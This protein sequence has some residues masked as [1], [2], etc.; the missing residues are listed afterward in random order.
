MW[1]LIEDFFDQNIVMKGMIGLGWLAV[2]CVA[3]VAMWFVL[4]PMLMDAGLNNFTLG[5]MMLG[6]L[7]VVVLFGVHIGIAMLVIGFVGLWLLKGRIAF[8]YTMLGIAGNEFLANYY[9]SAVP[10]FVMM[11][12]LV[13][14]AAEASACLR[15]AHLASSWRSNRSNPGPRRPQDST[16]A[17][18]TTTPPTPG[19]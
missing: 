5:A 2:T 13:A 19:P 12:L 16:A 17:G 18:V 3:L 9:F 6:V 10:L 4:F 15:L 11:G 7:V 1:H 14:A 8:G